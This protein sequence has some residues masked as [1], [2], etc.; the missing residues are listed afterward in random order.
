MWSGRW[1]RLG[2]MWEVGFEGWVSDGDPLSH[3]EGWWNTLR[4]LSVNLKR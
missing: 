2:G 4:H 3:L 1:R